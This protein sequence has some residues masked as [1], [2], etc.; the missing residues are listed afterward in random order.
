MTT[1]DFTLSFLVDQTPQEVFAA[2]NN[3]RGWWSEDFE[4]ASTKQGD[5]FSVRFGDV[6]YSRHQLTEVIPAKKIVWLVT[7]SCLNFLENKSEWTGTK[8]VECYK[9]CFNGWTQFLQH[10][11]KN[12]IVT[13][14]GNPNVLQKE[15]AQKSSA[16]HHTN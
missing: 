8:N 15:I 3:V 9:D 13:G 11:L 7:D 6:H 14:K 1:T 12:L 2:I 10:S 16:I 5:E 4:G